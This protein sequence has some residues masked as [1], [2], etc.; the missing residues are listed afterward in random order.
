MI[1]G[2]MA[3]CREYFEIL[4]VN[5]ICDLIGENGLRSITKHHRTH[6]KA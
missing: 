3:G 1:Q 4:F 6:C 2:Q 5:K